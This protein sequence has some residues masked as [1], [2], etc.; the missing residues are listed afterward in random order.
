MTT[1]SSESVNDQILF[2]ESLRE[3]LC[4]A[5][6]ITV[7]ENER[8]EKHQDALLAF[9]RIILRAVESHGQFML[10]L[11]GKSEKEYCRMMP[12]HDR[13]SEGEVD[14][15]TKHILLELGRLEQTLYQEAFYELAMQ[16]KITFEYLFGE[17]N[18]FLIEQLS[19]ADVDR[20]SAE[21]A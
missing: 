9:G 7:L 18:I 17:C 2:K 10:K 13:G 19:Q 21:R 4:I 15:L 1:Q 20:L 14:G 8:K 12:L 6:R 16:K 3:E 11:T 5:A